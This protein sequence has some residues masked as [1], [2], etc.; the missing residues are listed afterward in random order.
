MKKPCLTW[1]ALVLGVFFAG[2]V[3]SQAPAGP[4]T[5]GPGVG[6]TL[7]YP[8][9][10]VDFADPA[11]VTTVISVVNANLGPMLAR[12]VLWTDWGIPTLAFDVYLSDEGDVQTMNLRDVFAGILP[13]TGE[14]AN[15]AAFPGCRVNPPFHNNPVLTANQRQQLR[16]DHTGI[17]GPLSS[18][19]AGEPHG[20]NLARGY[21]TIDVVDECSGLES[22][23]PLVTPANATLPYFVDDGSA[24]GV[25]IAS[26]R[27]WGDIAYINSSGAAAQGSEAISLWA[28]PDLF[29]GADIFTFYGRY[30]GWDG[31]DERV[32]LPWAWD[33]RFLNGGAFAGG[34]NLIIWRDTSSAS[35]ARVRCGAHPGWYPL[36]NRGKADA[37]DPDPMGPFPFV[38]DIAPLAT[39]RVDLAFLPI[40]FG[41]IS[42]AFDVFPTCTGC[43]PSQA[44]VQPT[45]SA[46]NVLSVGWNGAPSGF[47]CGRTPPP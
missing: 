47:V 34:A 27:I 1:V 15:L 24:D 36:E 6:A 16:A 9:F 12:V 20:D 26:N 38:S 30:S 25:A 44:W 39:Q 40:D 8:L 22:P 41:V 3:A 2:N 4:C 29:D 43:W 23:S 17:A 13:S 32:P 35:I 31:R 21:I 45:L 37:E 28:D 5:I 42:L 46:G 19:C 10:E 7:L 14:A 18:L 33:Q 11:G